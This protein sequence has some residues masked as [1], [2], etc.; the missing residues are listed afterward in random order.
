MTRRLLIVGGGGHGRVIADTARQAGYCELAFLDDR[1]GQSSWGEVPCLGP[2]SVLSEVVHE[3]PAAIVALGECRTRLQFF[4]VIRANGFSIP[5]LVHPTAIISPDVKL[6]YGVYVGAGAVICTGAEIGDAVIVN[7]RACIDHD[8]NI[9]AGAHVAPGATL[10]GNVVLG[11]G[12]WIGTGA[13]VR[14]SVRIGAHATIGVGA[15]V[16]S[17]LE[18][19]ATY[20]GVPARP[21]RK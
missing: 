19:G 17:D 4:D 10:S 12:C 7:T 20:V 8:C 1:G 13:S 18:G 21:L 6:G 5:T 9:G 11:E 3:W 15:A 16:V 14:Q 2:F